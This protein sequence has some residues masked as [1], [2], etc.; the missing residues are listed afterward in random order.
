MIEKEKNIARK[1]P[2]TGGKGRF[3]RIQVRPKS[4]FTTFRTQDVGES[5]H[6]ERVAGKRPDGSW[7]TV[8]WLVSKSDA[9]VRGERLIIDSPKVRTALKQIRGPIVH[10]K[11]NVFKAKPRA[12]SK[13]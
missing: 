8:T 13:S 3:Y 7:D 10:S 5:G 9:H 1:K 4:T 12:R 2:G 6:L 11:G